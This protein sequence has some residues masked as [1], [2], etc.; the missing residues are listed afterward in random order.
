[1]TFRRAYDALDSLEQLNWIK[2]LGNDLGPAVDQANFVSTAGHVYDLGPKLA[3]MTSDHD[4]VFLTFESVIYKREVRLSGF[5]QAQSLLEAGC[6]ADHVVTGV[7]KDL[8]KIVGKQCI[9]FDDEN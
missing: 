5:C 7:R 8:L 1:V 6:N 3:K 4:A 2:W 9:V